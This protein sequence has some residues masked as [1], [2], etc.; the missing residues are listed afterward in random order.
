MSHRFRPQLVFAW[1]VL[2]AA[3]PA[4]PPAGLRPMTQADRPGATVLKCQQQAAN[5]CLLA[6]AAAAA[7]ASAS[8]PGETLPVSRNLEQT[9]WE[10]ARTP[11]QAGT[12]VPGRVAC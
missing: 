9:V 8:A 6:S 3:A 7:A 12:S 1:H 11:Q 4:P 10:I 5:D 2:T